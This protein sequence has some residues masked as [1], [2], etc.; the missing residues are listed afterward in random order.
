MFV[1]GAQQRTGMIHMTGPSRVIILKSC[2]IDFSRDLDPASPVTNVDLQDR[3]S[4]A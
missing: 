2:S 4:L 3:R 1:F